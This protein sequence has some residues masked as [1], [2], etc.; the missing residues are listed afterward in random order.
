MSGRVFIAGCLTEAA[1]SAQPGRG[2]GVQCVSLPFVEELAQTGD[3]ARR[4]W[5]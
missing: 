4:D 3:V 1:A 2:Q 5:T